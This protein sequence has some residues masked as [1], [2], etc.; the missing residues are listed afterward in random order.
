MVPENKPSVACACAA[1]GAYASRFHPYTAYSSLRIYFAGEEEWRGVSADA[2]D[3]SFVFVAGCTGVNR[4]A[5]PILGNP[6]GREG[7]ARE[8]ADEIRAALWCEIERTRR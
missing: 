5:Y 1:G 4:L 8:P 7:S 6:G 3:E 2:R